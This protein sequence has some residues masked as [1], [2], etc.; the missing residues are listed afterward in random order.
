MH[1]ERRPPMTFRIDEVSAGP[2][3]VLPLSGRLRSAEL[4]ALRAALSDQPRGTI[5]DLHDVTLVDGEAVRFFASCEDDGMELL[6]CSPYI[7]DSI[8]RGRR[9]R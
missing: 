5:L 7:R 3:K 6:N 9:R 8:L 1:R 2:P 4:E